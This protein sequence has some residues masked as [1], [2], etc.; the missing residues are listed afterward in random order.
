MA[1]ISLQ[2]L[3]FGCFLLVFRCVEAA[4]SR[5]LTAL[6]TEY[7]SA[8]VADPDWRGTWSLLYSSVFTLALC[9]WTAIHPN[10]PRPG[11]SSV[12]KYYFKIK[13]VIL[14][15]FAPEFGV[16]AAYKQH[17]RVRG[18]VA[19][20][21]RL[22]EQHEKKLDACIDEEVGSQVQSNSTEVGDIEKDAIHSSPHAQ[23][24]S[25]T[26]GF[27]VLMGG[28]S[29]NV[30]HIHDQL[31]KV[32]LSPNGVLHLAEK[33]H[34]FNIP[35]PDLKDK[36]KA[37][38]L[39]K[40]LVLLQITW[41]ILTCV[42][43][44]VVGLPLSILEVHI[45]VHAGCALIMYTL[46]FNKPLDVD[47]SVDVSAKAPDDIVALMLVQNHGFGMQPYGNNV[48]PREFRP[49]RTLGSRSEQWPSRRAP[50]AA[51][52]MYD[53]LTVSGGTSSVYEGV[54]DPCDMQQLNPSRQS[55]TRSGARTDQ[56][57]PGSPARV[58]QTQDI[59]QGGVHHS[60]QSP[61][62]LLAKYGRCLNNVFEAESHHFGAD[63]LD[64]VHLGF[65]SNP[66]SKV[67]VTASYATGEFSPGGIGPR[68]FLTG[69]WR[70]DRIGRL[71]YLFQKPSDIIE[72]PESLRKRLPLKGIDLST[73]AHYSPLT[74]SLSEKDARRWKLAAQALREDTAVSSAYLPE[75]D[76][77]YLDFQSSGGTL[78]GSYFIMRASL[79]GWFAPVFEEAFTSLWGPAKH[80]NR[81]IIL[82]Q[83]LYHRLLELE[84]LRL[85]STTAVVA[86]PGLL[87]GGVHLALWEYSFPSWPEE[88]LWK[89]SAT[90]LVAVPVLAA[91]LLVIRR[92]YRKLL[93]VVCRNRAKKPA[94]EEEASPTP[95][96]S[97]PEIGNHD[98]RHQNHR[99][100]D[101]DSSPI[102]TY[103]RLL[104]DLII[105]FAIILTLLYAFARV[106]IIVESF[107]S[108]R[109]VPRGVYSD[110]GW[111]RYVPH[112]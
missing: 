32:P 99:T 58:P 104:L 22:R 49:V 55:S 20:L 25:Q 84:E 105:P 87:Y 70:G 6:G 110:V 7:A 100:A 78:R 66:A 39:A 31:N 17:Q 60:S 13:W 108:L 76:A 48:L 2:D 52:L 54:S 47:E 29:I 69:I 74:I 43:R 56:P 91:A 68:A 71:S 67:P 85:G 94:K 50:E 3:L 11:A 51:F 14:A 82:L 21:N 9:V 86:L 44:K 89:I 10:V 80:S 24:F 64:H 4:P 63:Q 12:R 103:Q 23:S 36:S 37:S 45:L 107:I 18:F 33:G 53:P 5:N 95:N 109:H 19:D 83:G 28:L 98:Q 59:S 102:P 46:W 111:S 81:H 65:T 27:Y 38:F 77:Q 41:T 73:V 96:S 75:G 57:R 72:V 1:R 93:A 26:Y 62:V 16:L 112:L 8:F 61:N 40:G 79:L 42:S 34:F 90:T 97:D 106:F 30:S 35:D 15:I 92:V 101:P 88:I